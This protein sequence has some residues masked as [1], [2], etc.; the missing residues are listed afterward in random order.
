MGMAHMVLTMTMMVSIFAGSARVPALELGELQAVPSSYPP[1]IFRLPIITPPQGP[2]AIA[3]VTVRQPLDALSFV[4]QKVLELRLRALT[5]VE[6][7][8]SQGGQT[9]NRLLL[10]SELQAARMRLETAPASKSPQPIRAKGRDHPL[11]EAMPLTLASEDASHRA[12]LEREIEGIRQEIHNLVGRVTPWEGFSPTAGETGEST[13]TA[14]LTLMLGGLFIAGITTLVM[15]YV[16]QRQALDLERR[17]RRALILS[18]RRRQDQ[19]ARGVPIRPAVQPAPRSWA[20]HEALQPVTILRSVR[21]SQKTRRR[22]RGRASSHMADAAHEHDAECLRP[23]AQT[24]QRVPSAPAELLEALARLRYELMRLQRKPLTSATPK[25]PEV[26]SG[27]ACR[28]P[29]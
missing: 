18:I 26:R 16:M 20:A 3:A 25:N 7:E 4:Q 8:I 2:S 22:F 9:L 12:V 19:L 27:R 21:V 17:R 1:Y 29:W 13:M 6:L 15:G 23:M 14:V 24:S 11:A 28:E 5:D 10:K